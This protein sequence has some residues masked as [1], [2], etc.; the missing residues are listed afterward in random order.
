MGV[1]NARVWVK[2]NLSLHSHPLIEKAHDSKNA[3]YDKMNH[4]LLDLR[5]CK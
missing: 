5:K 1:R 2:A 3:S 4:V